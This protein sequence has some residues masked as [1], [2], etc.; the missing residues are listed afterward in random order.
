MLSLNNLHDAQT[1]VGDGQAAV[2]SK[3]SLIFLFHFII[4]LSC[5]LW[6]FKENFE[7]KL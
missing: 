1:V 6:A 5:D 2:A 4:Y 3:I 7:I